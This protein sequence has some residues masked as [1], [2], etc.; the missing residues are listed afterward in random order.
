M[1]I[2]RFEIPVTVDGDGAATVYSPILSGKLIS[3]RYVKPGS[4]NYTNGVDFTITAED[5]GETLWAEENVNASATRYPR[6]ALH[7]TAGAAAL[8]AGAGEAVNGKIEL[9]QDRV[10]IVIANA[11]S[12]IGTFHITI[13][14]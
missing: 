2:R 10:K 5:N 14:G 4:G 3:F 9:S 12:G 1:T 8:Y 13:D 11:V 7:S 6:A